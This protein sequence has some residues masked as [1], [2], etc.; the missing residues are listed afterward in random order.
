[1]TNHNYC[2]ICNRKINPLDYSNKKYCSNY[3]RYLGCM[4]RRGKL[5][6][7]E[8]EDKLAMRILK[9]EKREGDENVLEEKS[10]DKLE[11]IS[12]KD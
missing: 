9:F 7:K 2:K 11:P 6:I 4:V 3:C 8:A 12:K 5:T 10:M 1:M